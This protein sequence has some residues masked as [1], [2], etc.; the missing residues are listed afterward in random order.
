MHYMDVVKR[1][2]GITK[3]YKVLWWFGILVALTAGGSGG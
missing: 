3:R 2:F 1:A